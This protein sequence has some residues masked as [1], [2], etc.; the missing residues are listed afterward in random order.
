M[1]RLVLGDGLALNLWNAADARKSHASSPLQRPD[2]VQ[3]SRYRFLAENLH[4]FRH[5]SSLKRE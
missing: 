1:H 3:R 5:A 4:S 2:P